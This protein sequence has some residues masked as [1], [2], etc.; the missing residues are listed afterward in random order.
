[1]THRRPLLEVT[2][3]IC[4]SFTGRAA[5]WLIHLV[6]EDIGNLANGNSLLTVIFVPIGKFVNLICRISTKF[7]PIEHIVL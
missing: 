4:P 2:R 7:S 5:A 3:Q 6:G 1:M